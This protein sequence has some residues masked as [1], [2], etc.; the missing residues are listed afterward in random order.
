[1]IKVNTFKKRSDE[2]YANRPKNQG[3][4]LGGAEFAAKSLAAGV[5]SIGE[6]VVDIFGAAGNLIVGD[7]EGAKDMFRNNVVGDWYAAEREEYNPDGV[8]SFVGDTLHGIGQSAAL[9]IPYAGAP[10]FYAGIVSQGVSSAAA[11]T[12]EVGFKE[13]AYGGTMGALEGVIDKALGGT[14]STISNA[15]KGIGKNAGKSTG[16][17]LFKAT[18]DASRKGLTRKILSSA[19]SEFA[20]EFASEYADTFV[21]RAYRID[22]TKQYSLKDAVYSGF[23]GMVSGAV[24]TSAVEIPRSI[25]YA[26]KGRSIIDRGNSQTLVN[27]ATV[28]A[29]KLANKGT[30]FKNAAGWVTALRGQVDAYNDLV[31]KGKGDSASAATILGEMQAYLSYAETKAVHAGLMEKI[32]KASDEDKAALAEYINMLVDKENRKKDYTAEDITNNTDEIASQLAIMQFAGMALDYESITK[33]DMREQEIS[34]AIANERNTST[35]E[36]PAATVE[37]APFAEAMA[38]AEETPAQVAETVEIG[39]AVDTE[40]APAPAKTAADI[41]RGIKNATNKIEVQGKLYEISEANIDDISNRA[42]NLIKSGVSETDAVAQAIDEGLSDIRSLD[43]GGKLSPVFAKARIA[44]IK[45]AIINAYRQDIQNEAKKAAREAKLAEDTETHKSEETATEE[46]NAPE[47][48]TKTEAPNTSNYT[49]IKGAIVPNKSAQATKTKEAPKQQNTKVEE[50]S[51]DRTNESSENKTEPPKVTEPKESLT[52]EQRA[53]RARKRAK[54]MLEW[55]LNNTPTVNELNTAREYVK[56]FDNLSPE[57]RQ[58]II[59]MMRTAKGIDVKTVKGIANLMAIKAGADLDLRFDEEVSEYGVSVKS[60]GRTLIIISSKTD[61]KKTVK[62]TVAHELVHYLENKPGYGAFAKH[63]LKRVK[64]EK[65]KEVEDQVTKQYN[66]RYEQIYRKEYTKQGLKGAELNKAVKDALESAQHKAIIDSE[67]VAELVGQALNSDKFLSRYAR[68]GNTDGFIKKAYTFLRAMVKELKSKDKEN[69]ELADIIM[70][71]IK[72]MDRLLQM[73]TVK[74]SESWKKHLF[75]GDKAKTADKLKLATAK[76]MLKSGADSETVRRETG[77]FKGYDGKWKFEIDDSDMEYSRYGFNPDYLRYKE[78]ELKILEGTISDLELQELR[79]TPQDIKHINLNRLDQFVQ[80]EELFKAYPELKSINVKFDLDVKG[81]G[82]F[83][84]EK[85]TITLNPKT[86]DIK[87]TIIHEL[88]HAVQSIEEFSR[89][90]SPEYWRRKGITESEYNSFVEKTEMELNKEIRKL[91]ESDAKI[92]RKYFRLMERSGILLE[93]INFSNDEERQKT[94]EE[95]EK[96]EAETDKLYEYLYYQ[97]WFSRINELHNQI[98]ISDDLNTVFYKNTAGEIEARNAAERISLTPEER[99]N[100]RPDIDREDVV[101]AEGNNVAQSIEKTT[102]NRP[103]VVVNDDILKGVYGRSEEIAAVKQ[104]LMRFDKVPVHKQIILITGDSANEVTRSKQTET[105]RKKNKTIYEDKM[106]VMNHPVDI[107]LASTDFINEA[108]K[109]PRKDDII[110]FARGSILLQVHGRQYSAEV[111]YGYTKKRTCRLH[112]IV[113]I[114]PDSFTIKKTSNSLSLDR[115]NA[116]YRRNESLANNSIPQKSDLSTLSAKK[117]SLAPKE[118]Q[119]NA[120]EEGKKVDDAAY[121]AAVESG[122]METAQRMVDEAAR[123]AGYT[124][125]AY[126][127]SRHSGFTVFDDNKN[128]LAQKGFFFSSSP[129][130]AKSYLKGPDSS[131]YI[132]YIRMNNPLVVE[133]H[134]RNWDSLKFDI[135]DDA[136]TYRAVQRKD[137]RWEI[138]TV[139]GRVNIENQVAWLTKE[140]AVQA[141]KNA[142]Y[143]HPTKSVL[144]TTRDIVRYAYN[145]G[146][147]D[148]VIIKDTVDMGDSRAKRKI[149]TLYIPFSSQQ[150]KSTDPVTYDDDG[151]VIPLS[152]RF[153]SDNVDIRYSLAP[154]TKNINEKI[155]RERAENAKVENAQVFAKKDVEIA[156]RSI[157]GWTQEEILSLATGQE[158]LELQHMNKAKREEMISQIYIALHEEGAKGRVGPGHVAVKALAANIAS[159]YIDSAK[160]VGENNKSVHLKEIYDESSINQ[161]KQDLT[162]LLYG[163]FAHMGHATRNADFQAIIR[164]QKEEFGQEQ[165]SATRAGKESRNLAYQ[166]KKLRELVEKQKRDATA[167]DI[168]KVTKAMAD[169]ID[170]KGNIRVNAVDKAMSEASRF[171]E[172]EKAKIESEKNALKTADGNATYTLSD[173][174]W[175]AND[176]IKFMIDEYLRLRE[177][178]EGKALTAEEMRLAS[179]VLHAMKVTIERYNKEYVNGHWIDAEEAAKDS[180]ADLTAAWREK[181]YKNKVTEWLGNKVVKGVQEKYFYKILTPETIVETL[182]GFAKNGLLKS[183]YH[184]IRVHKQKAEHLAVQLKKPLAEFMDNKENGW[185]DD[186]GH[187]RSFRSKLNKKMISVNGANGVVDLTLGEAIYLFMLTKREAAHAGL[188]ENGYIVYNDKNQQR[189]K[190]RLT[191]IENTR[192]NIYNAFDKTDLEFLEMA[193]NFFNKTSSKIKYDADMNI[194]GYTNIQDGYYVPMIRDRYSRMHGVTDARQSIGSIITVYNKSFNQNLVEN[195]NALEGKNIMSIISDHADGLADYSELYL[196][197]K[198]FDR[199]YNRA[200]VTDDGI[201]S[202]RKVL[203][204][205][206]WNGTERYFKDLFADIQGQRDQRDN[207]VDNLVGSIRSAWVN[208]VLGANVKVVVTQTTSLAAATQV[209]NA[210]YIAQTAYLA[211]PGKLPGLQELRERAYKYSDIIEARNFDMGAIKAQGN[212]DKVTWLGEKSGWAIGWMDERICLAIF[213][214]AELQIQAQYG[215]AVGTE[216]NAKLAAKLA[217]EAIYTTQA[218]SS[219]SERSALQRSTSEIAKMFSMFT[220]DTVKNLSHLYGNIMK[221]NAFRLRAKAGDNTYAAEMKECGRDIRKSMRTL[222]ITGVMLGLITQAFKYLFGKAEED[223]EEQKKDLVA[224]VAGSTLNVLPIVSEFVDKIF[225][226]YDMSINVLDVA[227][228]TLEA[229]RGGMNIAGKSIK[230]EYV[231]TNDAIKTSTGIIMSGLS[232]TGLPVSPAERLVTG[233]LRFAS[234]EAAYGYNSIFNSPSYTSD[235]KKAVESGDADLAEYIL[236]RLYKDEMA[237]TY[238]VP[239][240]EE[241]VRLYTLT[242]EEGNHYNVLPKRTLKKMDDDTELNA[243]QRKQFNKIYSQSSAKVNELIRSDYYAAL[244][245]KAKAKAISNIYG[246]YFDSAKAQV[247]GKEWSA[248]QAYSKLTDNYTVLMASKAYKSSLEAYKTDSGKEVTVKEQFSQYVKNLNLSDNDY[249]IVAYA[250]G[251]KGKKTTRA[252]LKYM[253]SLDLNEAE[254][255]QIAKALNFDLKN[256]QFTEK[257]D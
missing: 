92:V 40:S 55:E 152:A 187:K 229:V 173:F 209:I 206:V 114:V 68:I 252:L 132:E 223:P 168:V 32:E 98:E 218:M 242:D 123:G 42:E 39:Q 199:I 162:D 78:L 193:E 43:E 50:K 129:E 204:N 127:G 184:S 235:L 110:D 227:N 122:D 56:G 94:F 7:V 150:I 14:A 217:D 37:D 231:S 239:E 34:E 125:K 158:N 183:L 5:G 221:W 61:F 137:G 219:A 91:S 70:P 228:D 136:K 246:L 189:A 175:M 19:A 44:K 57:R 58:S 186:N 75:A 224:D 99:K 171:F 144:N 247:M 212:I 82:M 9:F 134:K 220:S 26:K 79:S 213:H 113:K 25:N 64:P 83:T 12:G 148:G 24:T 190:L 115:N 18:T 154:K 2:L 54:E 47:A 15:V 38:K 130:V 203:N 51:S 20:E 196:P 124:V 33:D 45:G 153:K 174:A 249:L 225:F 159:D 238:T 256:G 192:N 53:E 35:E 233:L 138:H 30:N 139:E 49:K 87:S 251:Y 6:G 195:A 60:E 165:L 194:F 142:P 185:T 180:I 215:H 248:N 181:E 210:K 232:F 89:G 81:N 46:K 234:P 156:V 126:H 77:W 257:E 201:T 146:E 131:L 135:G 62:G 149:S 167:E 105:I 59:R 52:D 95:V 120:K 188:L 28:V 214:A 141:Y 13:I 76:K 178:R 222:A 166:G 108:P 31:K 254:K 10:L 72:S 145:N 197:L 73:P 74:D 255:Q 245:D 243:A 23:V 88:Q 253:N 111:V 21:Q 179:E 16:K 216:E 86:K 200:I 244:D 119:T 67:V 177:G 250:N 211:S 101:F 236:E 176:D 157:E 121:M 112:D 85:L 102:D 164:K 182:E 172:G 1:M 48:E 107:V 84:P 90:S 109:H 97:P 36:T 155:A 22:P 69:N 116:E 241:I 103:V 202:I 237:G 117:Y 140:D 160:I 169:V 63:V 4:L 80:H 128:D 205:D 163:E 66:E 71:T 27:T 41:K 240:L 8:M 207:V 11:K 3:G 93:K 118:S 191:D 29:D 230:G 133:G 147:Y 170:A 65:K 104:A 143:V 198:A 17:A 226:D 100:T 96:I 161:F 208:S 151:N 106:R